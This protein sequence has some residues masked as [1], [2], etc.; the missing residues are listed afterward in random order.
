MDY[1][2]L[3]HHWIKYAAIAVAIHGVVLSLPLYRSVP[4][5]VK[6]RLVDVEIIRQENPPPPAPRE[7][8][9]TKSA[10]RAAIPKEAPPAVKEAVPRGREPAQPPIPPQ[11]QAP[12]KKTEPAG[13]GAGNVL[14]EQTAAQAVPGPAG[15]EGVGV[16]GVNTAGGK[17]GLGGGGTGSGTGAG[18]TGA[19][20]GVA[21]GG[22][23]GGRGSGEVVRLSEPPAFAHYEA[24]E[25]PARARR[26]G[27]E[28]KVVLELTID[29]K[30]QVVKVDVVEATDQMFVTPSVSAAKRWKFRPN[31]RNG[32]PV[33]C[34]AQ[35]VLPFLIKD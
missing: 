18:G 3:R 32:T 25:Y 21:A 11:P 8:E 19:G 9:E 34:R 33:T 17:V 20:T 22:G 16:A 27:R 13:A 7:K 4:Q 29:E 28:G 1:W 15:D 14:D 26:L 30:G 23:G 10:S 12:E 6:E 31:T 5:A 24:P 2:H 35:L